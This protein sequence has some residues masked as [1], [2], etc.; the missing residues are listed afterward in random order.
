MRYF[1]LYV[2]GFAILIAGLAWGAA[3]LDVPTV[4]ITV[5][6]IILAGIGIIS[7]VSAARKP[8]I[9]AHIDE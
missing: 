9:E 1:V 5:G 7:G 8:K 6:A 3:L 2:L 4:W